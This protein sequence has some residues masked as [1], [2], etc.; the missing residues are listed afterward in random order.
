MNY[1]HKRK[2]IICLFFIGT[3]ICFGS[4]SCSKSL[5]HDVERFMNTKVNIPYNAL[6]CRICSDYTDTIQDGHEF[7]LVT[8]LDMDSVGCSTCKLSAIE[9][10]EYKI[11]SDTIV[12]QR[13]F[14]TYIVKT[15]QEKMEDSYHKI[16]NARL[17]GKVYFDTCDTLRKCNPEFPESSLLHTFMT[18]TLGKVVMVG[19]PYLNKDMVKVFR[20][21][22][23]KHYNNQ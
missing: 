18:D 17:R 1:S 6:E 4:L 14:I 21:V 11:H 2:Y 5:N 8:F 16:C 15:S 7:I 20:K 22:I 19:N 3:I 10:M 9:E 23:N 13:V 12:S